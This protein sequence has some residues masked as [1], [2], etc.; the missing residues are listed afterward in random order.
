MSDFKP[1]EKGA[2]LAIAGKINHLHIICSKQFFNKDAGAMSVLAVN[3]SSVRPEAQFDD[4]CVLHAGDHPFI[5]HDSYVRYKDAVVMKVERIL[6][7]IDSGEITVLEEVSD[8][9]FERVLAGFEKSI[10]TK[11]KIKK[12][13]RE[14]A[15]PKLPAY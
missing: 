7:A 6:S 13:V 12:L 9:V 5:V 4:T 15:Q 1:D 10:H 14:L 8:D 3:V 11:T 2:I